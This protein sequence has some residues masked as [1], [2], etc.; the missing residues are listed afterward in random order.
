[1]GLFSPLTDLQVCVH[2]TWISVISV[3]LTFIMYVHVGHHIWCKSYG[4]PVVNVYS[5]EEGSLRKLPVISVASE[6]LKVLTGSSVLAISMDTLALKA[7]DSVLQYV[8][9][10]AI[11]I[12]YKY[13]ATSIIQIPFSM[14]RIPCYNTR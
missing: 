1:M 8:H 5:V 14:F 13:S 11:H 7:T 6:T 2:I 12:S 10:S 3:L 9:I 4:S